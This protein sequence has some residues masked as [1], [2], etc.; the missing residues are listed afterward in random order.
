MALKNSCRV[1]GTGLLTL[2]LLVGPDDQKPARWYAGG[3]CG[4]VLAIL[5]F[6]GWE[7]FPVT[8]LNGDI[9]S[10][11][12]RHDL[13]RWGVNLEYAALAPQVST[14]IIVQRIKRRA[15]GKAVHS[16]SC[17]CPYCGSW[18]PSFK[19]V[20]HDTALDV[21]SNWKPPTVFFFDRVSRGMLTLAKAAADSGALVVFEPSA[22]GELRH[23]HEALQMAHIVK[24]SD[25]RFP[26]PLSAM[27]IGV[28][29][30]IEIQT[31]GGNGYRF[32]FR[33]AKR[34][35]NWKKKES[36]PTSE[37]ADTAGAGDWF[38]AALIS[39]FSNG[40]D[41]LSGLRANALDEILDYANSVAAWNCFFE[42]ARGGMYTVS[43]R[44]FLAHVRNLQ[45]GHTQVRTRQKATITEIDTIDLSPACPAC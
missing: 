11:I 21:S 12:V 29:T 26:E 32:R 20:R 34:V 13:Q 30:R 18:L 2:D 3:T 45:D 10:R 33:L 43:K 16:F 5:S 4:N 25:Q 8:R 42:G 39:K 17:N 9:A 38:T 44:Q 28:N 22:K 6:L 37:T 27:E 14:P 41:D 24:Y 40:L 19:P 1:Y 35:S 31:L 23:M 15:S 36:L 7:S